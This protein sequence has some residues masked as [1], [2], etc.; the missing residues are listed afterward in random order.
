L[1]ELLGRYR[2]PHRQYHSVKHVE[3]VVR[4]VAWLLREVEVPAGAALPDPCA[5]VLAAFFHDA[6][7]D[8]RASDNEASS[9]AL[10]GRVLDELRVDPARIAEVERLVLAT[11]HLAVP[12][13]PSLDLAGRPG[14]EPAPDVAA[15]ILLDADLAILGAEPSVYE[16]YVNGVRHEY[17]HLDDEQWAAGRRAVLRL[18]LDRE[19]I[20]LT[21]PMHEH[22]RRAR[23]NLTAELATLD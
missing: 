4:D 2:E 11:A 7:Y 12:S 22:E 3:L 21:L 14:G 8:A 1:D 9:A 5:V 13:P 10:A 6:V 16:A 17:A 19:A 23:A 20:Y 18:F 15:W